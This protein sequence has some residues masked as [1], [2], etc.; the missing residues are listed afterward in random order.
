MSKT[1]FKESEQDGVRLA[2]FKL[3]TSLAMFAI[4]LG[5]SSSMATTCIVEKNLSEEQAIELRDFL[6]LHY[7]LG[8]TL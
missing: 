2:I 8:Q 6:N 5:N 1:I 3:D 7:P 4:D